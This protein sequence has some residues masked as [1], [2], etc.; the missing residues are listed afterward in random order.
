MLK[1]DNIASTRQYY[2]ANFIVWLMVLVLLLRYFQIQI[3]GHDRYS[4]KANA[5]RI[6]KVTTSAP[7]G[8]I[9]DRNGQILVDNLPTYILEAIPGELSEKGEKFGLISDIIGLDSN[10]VSK[11]YKKYWAI[12]LKIEGKKRIVHFQQQECSFESRVATNPRYCGRERVVLSLN[13][14]VKFLVSA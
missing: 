5:N 2:L 9:L 8:L 14:D 6:R 11:N 1:A 13:L 12:Y 3:L 4:K 10:T 7:R